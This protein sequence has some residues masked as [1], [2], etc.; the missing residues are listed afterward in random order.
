MKGFEDIYGIGECSTIHQSRLANTWM[1]IFRSLDENGDGFV[2]HEEFEQLIE[3]FAG[4]FPQLSEFSNHVKEL[5]EEG[6]V[7]KD[8]KL[9]TEEFQVIMAKV[10]SIMTSLPR[11]AQSA[12]Q[13][14]DIPSTSHCRENTW[15]L[16]LTSCL[17]KMNFTSCLKNWMIMEMEL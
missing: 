6:D 2:D 17:T 8:G 5:F 15:E 3:K 16:L 12:Q 13:Q 4:K 11:T 9:S 1:D 10:D 14:V 7:N